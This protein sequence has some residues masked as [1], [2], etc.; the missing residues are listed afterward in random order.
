MKSIEHP[1]KVSFGKNRS[2]GE[3][4]LKGFMGDDP[5]GELREAVDSE[6]KLDFERSLSETEMLFARAGIIA[7]S[8]GEIFGRDDLYGKSI[9]FQRLA[10][11]YQRMKNTEGFVPDLVIAPQ[12]LSADIWGKVLDNLVD[13]LVINRDVRENWELLNPSAVYRSDGTQVPCYID[14]K[15]FCWTVRVISGAPEPLLA[16]KT[17]IKDYIDGG[18]VACPTISELLTMQ[19]RRMQEIGADGRPASFDDN[20]ITW[21]AGSFRGVVAGE[22]VSPCVGRRVFETYEIVYDENTSSWLEKLVSRR[23]VVN[24]DLGK[25]SSSRKPLTVRPVVG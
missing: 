10:R 8:F 1:E 15:G 13:N 7:P 6:I 22:L 12:G 25:T 19:G 9:N 3:V 23:Y 16:D 5:S 4:S 2:L 11:L 18:G 14:N 21:A 24:V 20:F 17:S